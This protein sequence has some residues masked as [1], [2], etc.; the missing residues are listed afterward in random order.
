MVKMIQ[1]ICDKIILNKLYERLHECH[2]KIK[3]NKKKHTYST[4][5]NLFCELVELVHWVLDT[6]KAREICIGWNIRGILLSIGMVDVRK[7]NLTRP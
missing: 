5:E 3:K 6:K 4:V 2:T 1:L 7:N